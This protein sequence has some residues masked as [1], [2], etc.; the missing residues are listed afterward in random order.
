MPASA[1]QQLRVGHEPLEHPHRER[2][3][4]VLL[5]VEVEERAVPGRGQVQRPQPLDHAVD[6]AVGVPRGQLAG[7]RRDLDGHVVDVGPLDQGRHPRQPGGRLA[8]PEHGLA[9]QVEVEPEALRPR[10]R[11][12][13]W[14]GPG[15]RRR[16]GGRRGCAAA[17]GRPGR[18][19]RAARARR[20]HRPRASPGR[21]GR[22]SPPPRPTSDRRAPVPPPGRPADEPPGR[23]TAP[24]AR[25]RRDRRRAPPAAPSCVAPWPSGPPPSPRAS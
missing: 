15:R 14:P 25:A 22:G 16:R 1:P 6:A 9:E 2:E 4:A 10:A 17:A 13:A 20:G 18:R 24:R 21:A 5:H 11:P 7:H 8:L 23:R 19:R 3:V 12:G